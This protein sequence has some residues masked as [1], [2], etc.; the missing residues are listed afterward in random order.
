MK[1]I[2]LQFSLYIS[3]A[4]GIL[5][6]ASFS[7]DL[8]AEL[9]Y[10]AVEASVVPAA[11][12]KEL[13]LQIY[14]TNEKNYNDIRSCI[15]ATGGVVFNGYCEK[16]Y[17]FMYTV[18]MDLQPEYAF[19]NKLTSKGYTYL[20]KEGSTIEQVQTACGMNEGTPANHNSETE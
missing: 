15:E 7:N 12:Y 5:T 10:G 4:C 19:L 2:V 3:A 14:G 11:Q 6:T 17:I 1:K 18:N 13:I 9:K 8:P 16:L 20:I